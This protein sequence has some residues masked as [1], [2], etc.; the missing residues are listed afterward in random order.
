MIGAI[1][2]PNFR[3]REFSITEKVLF[4]IDLLWKKA[5]GDEEGKLEAYPVSSVSHLVKNVT[6]NRDSDFDIAAVYVNNDQVTGKQKNIGRFYV[7]GVHKSFDGEAQAVKVK[8]KFNEFG[9]LVVDGAVMNEKLEQQPEEPAATTATAA[10]NSGDASNTSTSTP[11]DTSDSSNA[12]GTAQGDANPDAADNQQQQQQAPTTATPTTATPNAEGEKKKKKL[13]K[14]VPLVVKTEKPYLKSEA[15]LQ[16]L[17]EVELEM[18]AQDRHE[19]EKS[20]ARNALEEYIYEMRDKIT[21]IYEE[22]MKPDEREKFVSTLQQTENWLYEDGQDQPK[23]VYVDKLSA[24][25]GTGNSV[26][27]R[28]TEAQQRP[29]A[30]EAMKHTIVRIR[31]FIA[32]FR[33]GDEKY[34][35]IDPKNVD[36][37][38]EEVNKKDQWLNEN[39]AKQASANKWDTPVLSAAS[40]N[41]Q[42]EELERLTNPTINTPKP[43]VEPPKQPEPPK[44]DANANANANAKPNTDSAPADSTQ[45]PQ[46]D[47]TKPVDPMDLD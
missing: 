26:V 43:K 36:K 45:N 34:N 25:K 14:S 19:V 6:F 35:H 37:V 28:H 32:A 15:D 46:T 33:A 13:H 39:L 31:K 5:V 40:I 1:V 22:Y 29:E 18:A 3:V 8:V 38:E 27:T 21:T 10:A 17:V 23:N 24:L 30:E 12:G 11:M 2:S 9:I 42:R 41:L 44:T 7:E 16:K 4:G 20:N 47:A